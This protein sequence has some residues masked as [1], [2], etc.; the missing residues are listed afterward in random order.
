MKFLIKESFRQNPQ[1]LQKLFETG[2]SLITHN[3]ETSK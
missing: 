1:A 3:Q 2:D